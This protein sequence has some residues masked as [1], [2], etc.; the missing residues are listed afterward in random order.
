MDNIYFQ[1]SLGL[2]PSML[3]FLILLFRQK[4]HK[5]RNTIFSCLLVLSFLAGIVLGIGS[6]IGKRTTDKLSADESI[7]FIYSLAETGDTESSLEI[8]KEVR[9]GSVYNDSLTLCA[10]RLY[11]LRGNFKASRTLYEKVMK[12]RNNDEISK[13]HQ[14]VAKAAEIENTDYVLLMHFET[15]SSDT[16]SDYEKVTE[17]AYKSVNKAIK[18]V[19]SGI[20]EQGYKKA[21]KLISDTSAQYDRF[22]DNGELDADE[23]KKQLKKINDLEEEYPDLFEIPQLRI[24]RLKQQILCGDFKGIAKAVDDNSDYN[25]LLIVSELYMNSYIRSSYFSDDFTGGYDKK[26]QKVAEQLEKVYDTHY[27]DESR[28]VR[29]AVRKQIDILENAAEDP[30]IYRIEE[31]LLDYARGEN[32]YDSTKVYLQL[33]KMANYNGNEKQ[34]ERYISSSFST[35]SECRDDN[36]TQP[37]YKIIGIISEKDDPEKVKNVAEYVDKILTNTTNIRMSETHLTTNPEA[38]SDKDEKAVREETATITAEN[39]KSYLTDYVSKKRASI[40]IVKVD[41]SEFPKVSALINIDDDLSYSSEQLKKLLA[42]QDCGADITDFTVEK[43]DYTK[44]N[45]LLCCDVSPSMAGIGMESLKEAIVMFVDNRTDADNI[46]LLTFSGRVENFYNFGTSPDELIDI[47][48]NLRIG[49]GT[50][51]YDAIIDCLS[52]FDVRPGELNCIIL[53]SDGEDNYP[54]TAEEIYEYIGKPGVDKGIT[55][56]SIGLGESVDSQ[57]LDY[58]AGATGGSYLYVNNYDSLY[59]F[60]EYLHN[61]ILNQYR[62]TFNAEDTLSISRKLKVSLT[63]DELTYD[64][65]HYS[66]ESSQP[67]VGDSE[68]EYKPIYLQDKSVIGLD[69]KLVFKSDID[70]T[71]N[72]LGSG[73]KA[74]DKISVE[75]KGNLNY[76]SDKIKCEFIDENKIKVVIPA[77]IACGTYNVHVTIN[78]KKAILDNGLVVAT[79]G[80]EKMTAFGPYVFTSYVKVEEKNSVTLSGLVTMNG[81]LHFDG[82]VVLTGD[83]E[84]TM[85]QMTDTSGGYIKYYTGT[86]EGLAKYLAKNNKVVEL[87]PLG[88]LNL[89]NDPSNKPTSDDYRVDAVVIPMVYFADAFTMNAPGLMLYPD[90]IVLDFKKFDTKFPFQDKLMKSGEAS[91]AF[92]F[93][94]D[95]FQCLLTSKSIGI[96]FEYKSEH[97]TKTYRQFNFGSMP[98]YFTPSNFELKINTVKNEYFIKYLTKVLF[99]N[100]DGIGLSIKWDGDLVPKEV[101]LYAD[102]DLNTT[103][104]GLP[105]TFSDFKLGVTDIDKNKNILYWRLEGGMDLTMAKVSAA[106]P[107]L[108]KYI[109]D[110]NLVKFDDAKLSF[111]LGQRHISVSSDVK[112]FGKVTVA[113]LLV[114]AGNFEYENLL[115]GMSDEEV[116]GLHVRDQRGIMWESDNC[117]ID[118]SGTMDLALTNRVAGVAVNGTCDLDV[119]WWVFEKSFYSQG[120][121]FIGVYKNHRNEVSFVVKARSTTKAKKIKEIYLIWTNGEGFDYGTKKFS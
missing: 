11:A 102:F 22:T 49:N 110:V 81:W 55:I 28:N 21:A 71:V 107:K 17:E 54:K 38:Q 114:E 5:A 75:I 47:A 117:D 89:Y 42:I 23:A 109:G 106:L 16:P 90:R 25:E 36:F 7:N 101:M 1:V 97:D 84:S 85:I 15:D 45:I 51:M 14:A 76:G 8:L 64:I 41:A 58:F 39:F 88:T 61:Q 19:V 104:S 60:Y 70:Y 65:E 83:L 118:L 44:A 48:R 18:D 77:G 34:A 111:S 32:A 27:S 69:P 103:I 62:I 113:K 12:T 9:E 20:K 33:S 99:I 35:V 31:G 108:E 24:A 66:L 121:A 73:F 29:E 50:N 94:I 10:A 67:A 3:V 40:N 80:S 120:D 119:R 59:S 2:V 115:L 93:D 13:E 53:L 105:V 87:P 82:D 78:G 96:N 116:T 63:G 74:E 68:E 98:M 91:K 30:V 112:L 46:A 37:M 79:Q 43:I 56:Y 86:S 52:R 4:K 95:E 100:A 92:S 26:Y 6:N 72:L 57:Y